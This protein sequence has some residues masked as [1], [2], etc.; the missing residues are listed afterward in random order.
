MP[1]K[2]RNRDTPGEHRV[3]A[4]HEIVKAR[5]GEGGPGFAAELAE[6]LG[7]SEG[8]IRDRRS[9]GAFEMGY[10]FDAVDFIGDDPLRLIRQVIVTDPTQI[11]DPPPG[12]PPE[13]VRKTWARLAG[14]EDGA[15]GE[16]SGEE[17]TKLEGMR[18]EDPK[19]LVRF[20]VEAV[21]RVELEDLPILLGMLGSAWRVLG[22]LRDA[23]HTIYAGW[24]ISVRRGDHLG[25]ARSVQRMAYV[26]GARGDHLEALRISKEAANLYAE[27]GDLARMGQ[28]FVDQ[29]L[30]LNYLGHPREG[31]RAQE[32]ALSY[33]PEDLARSRFSAL[34]NLARNYQDL[35]QLEE[36]KTCARQ[37]REYAAKV[38]PALLAKLV[39]FQ[40]KLSLRLQEWAE[41]E[42][43]FREV[44]DLLGS[45]NPLDVAL[46]STDLIRLQ[47][48][49]GRPDEGHETAKSM[50]KLMEP[51]EKH[52][53][54]SAAVAELFRSG[55][56]SL[57]I[58]VVRRAR[59]KI[60]E[61]RE[62]QK[63]RSLEGPIR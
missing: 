12:E 2:P 34:Q 29:G 33:L 36:A 3:R 41:A 20:A 58:S 44:I 50:L 40:A 57:T 28:T 26:A 27:A 38:E 10:F 15:G 60:E 11:L 54:A 18:Y 32:A 13:V 17:L 4:I 35:G 59:A 22:R 43:Q 31:I 5:I 6:S 25:A 23:E 37:A 52:P 53:L 9:V 16:V 63:R 39:W 21:D 30:F 48:L 62:R 7:V 19:K 24:Q 55:V 1:R 14:K 61:E 56:K 46:A 8:W 42:T 51:L 49:R 47:L 45:I